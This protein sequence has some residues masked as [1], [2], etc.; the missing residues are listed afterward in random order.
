MP[1]RFVAGLRPLQPRLYSIASSL[2]AAPDEAHLT[3]STVRYELHGATAHRRRL[4]P[5]RRRAPRRMRTL[6]VYIQSNPHF[7]LPDDDV[8][9]IMIG[10]G[11]RRR[12]VPRLHAGARGARRGRP[13]LAVL[14]RAQFPQRL[15]LSGRMAGVAQGRRA[16]PHGRRVLARRARRRSM[17]STGCAEQG[18]D[19]YA[20]LEEGAHLYV[21]G[22]A[23]AHGARRPRGA[24]RH[25]R[26]ARRP[27][28]RRRRRTISRRCSATAA[29]SATSTEAMS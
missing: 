4:R 21:C 5:S 16:D 10:A 8:P 6:P 17:C 20:W 14:R 22:D 7:R 26:R 2:A 28:P 23:R 25:R 24:D 29:T 3:V 15:P 1:R 13:L 12:A 11:H 9:I 27:R 19:V 18:R